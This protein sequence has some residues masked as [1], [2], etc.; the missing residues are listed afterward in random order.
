MATQNQI[1]ANRKNA[2][3][4]T[5]P[6]TEEGKAVV[7]QNAL[8]H[9]L[10]A[11]NPLI[12]GEDPEHF[13]IFNDAMLADLNPQGPLETVLANRITTLT[14]QLN[15]APRLQAAAVNFMIDELIWKPSDPEM[16]LGKIVEKDFART[17]VLEKLQT[18]E[19][20]IENNLYKTIEKLEKIQKNRKN[21]TESQNSQPEPLTQSTNYEPPNRNFP[22]NKPD[23]E[24]IQQD[25]HRPLTLN[26]PPIPP[27]S[28]ARRVQTHKGPCKNKP[29]SPIYPD[30]GVI[31]QP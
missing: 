10:T 13:A 6:K 7:A 19:Q 1:A 30:Q 28:Q 16:Q 29:N 3:K 11:Q 27:A 25:T 8:K 17:H 4:S 21:R 22:Q 26:Q 2:K 9:G 31:S 15:R 20:K 18:Y 23:S 5:G 14:W 12:P 24:Q